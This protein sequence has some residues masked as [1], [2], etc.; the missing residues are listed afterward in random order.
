[1]RARARQRPRGGDHDVRDQYRKG[2]LPATS[3]ISIAVIEDP[4]SE[5]ARVDAEG[6]LDVGAQLQKAQHRDGTIA[7]GAP[8]WSPPR[9]PSITVFV[10]LKDDPVGRMHSRH[11]IDKAQYQA[12]RAFQQ[13]AE[14][15][16]LGSVRSVDLSKTKVSGGLPPDPLT[17]HRRRAMSLLRNAEDRVARRYGTAGLGLTRAI[18]VERR[19]VEATARARGAS[20]SREISFWAGLFRRCFDVLATAFGFANSTELPYRPNGH[21]EEDPVADPGRH[22]D[23]L[24]LTDPGLRRRRANGRG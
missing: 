5:A 4:Y 9:R 14:Q 12:A 23:E 7:E 8:G 6:N 22:A 13:V 17:D 16:T 20:S 15:A 21:A 18:L 2:D 10:A 11:Q 3:R 1:M 24:E 19:S